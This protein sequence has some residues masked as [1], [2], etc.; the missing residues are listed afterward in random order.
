MKKLKNII[1]VKKWIK[2]IL[3]IYFGEI[4]YVK[5]RLEREKKFFN[6]NIYNIL[7]TQIKLLKMR[8]IFFNNI[9]I[10]N[11]DNFSFLESLN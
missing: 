4:Y 3:S 9:T 5:L 10:N 8:N 2:L 1:L 6:N 11:I 7:K